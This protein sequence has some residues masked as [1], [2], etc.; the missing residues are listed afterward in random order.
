MVWEDILHIKSSAT[1]LLLLQQNAMAMVFAWVARSEME[2][3]IEFVRL[4]DELRLALA[5]SEI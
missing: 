1:F 5:L 4:E 2:T 3:C